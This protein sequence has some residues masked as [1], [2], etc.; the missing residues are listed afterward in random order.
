T[1]VPVPGS[2][3]FDLASDAEH[4]R[5]WASVNTDIYFLAEGKW[6]LLVDPAYSRMVDAEVGY[7]A[8][9]FHFS[10]DRMTLWAVSFQGFLQ[11]DLAG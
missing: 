1:P 11:I 3:V 2:R 6:Q 10:A 8:R 7:K 9:N 4:E 5:L